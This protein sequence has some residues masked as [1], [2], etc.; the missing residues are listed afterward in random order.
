MSLDISFSLF[1]KHN[2]VKSSIM[3][4]LLIAYYFECAGRRNLFVDEQLIHVFPTCCYVFAVSILVL[5]YKDVTWVFFLEGT[6]GK[7]DIVGFKIIFL[8]SLGMI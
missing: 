7:I 1:L 4:F 5:Y 6:N 2:F 3:M 8:A